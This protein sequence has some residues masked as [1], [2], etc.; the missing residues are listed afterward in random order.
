VQAQEAVA[1]SAEQ[2]ITAL[3][4]YNSAKG[5]IAAALGGAEEAVRQIL[6]DVR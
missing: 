1:V 5:L 2:Y 4:G 3:Y 6:G